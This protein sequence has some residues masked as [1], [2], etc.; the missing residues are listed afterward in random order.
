MRDHLMAERLYSRVERRGECLIWT[1]YVNPRGHGRIRRSGKGQ[2]R[3]KQITTHVA[4][5]ELEFGPVPPGK[6]LHH[7][8]FTPACIDTDHLRP[9]THVEHAAAH[10]VLRTTCKHGH[11]LDGQKRCRGRTI[12]YCKT[13]RRTWDLR[14]ASRRRRTA[15]P[16]GR[17]NADAL[18]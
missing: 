18:K 1:G 14:R 11:P 10:A 16:A 13:C 8:C 4:A 7:T 6:E 12:R 17:L 5:W 15:E 9:L 3:G 2:I